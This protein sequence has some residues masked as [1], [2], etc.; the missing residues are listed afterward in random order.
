MKMKRI[1]SL[2]LPLV[3]FASVAMIGTMGVSAAETVTG[4]LGDT[5]SNGKVNIKDATTVQKHC[6]AL[7][8]LDETAL[9]LADANEDDKVNVKDASAIQKFLASMLKDTKIG[10]VVEMNKEE[11]SKPVEDD[12]VQTGWIKYTLTDENGTPVE[13]IEIG[14]WDTLE[15]STNNNTTSFLDTSKMITSKKTDKNGVVYFDNVK[16]DSV[17]YVQEVYLP[18]KYSFVEYAEKCV[19]TDK[20]ID[21]ENALEVKFG[22]SYL[23]FGNAKVTVVD[24]KGKTLDGFGFK[25]YKEDGSAIM[26]SPGKFPYNMTDISF[27]GVVDR[28]MFAGNNPHDDND[29]LYFELGMLELGTYTLLS[30]T[31]PDGYKIAEKTNIT[32]EPEAIYHN[33]VLRGYNTFTVDIVLTA[34]KI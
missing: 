2:A 10:T 24:K 25:L 19:V 17:Y 28:E 26:L 22:R 5:D 23:T 27:I 7:L 20:N 34:E 16:V 4:V 13:G 1:V 12:K 11:D 30:T 8:T 3:I 6:A 31:V 29:D 21:K 15:G 18:E 14:L 9:F 32:I 33:D